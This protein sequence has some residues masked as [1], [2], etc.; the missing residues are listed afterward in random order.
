MQERKKIQILRPHIGAQ[1]GLHHFISVAACLRQHIAQRV[2]D[3]TA[4]VKGHRVLPAYAV[5]SGNEN[6][7]GDSVTAHH[8]TPGSGG[9]QIGR[10][11]LGTDRGRIVDEFRAFKRIDP[12]Q[13][14]KPLIV[15]RWALPD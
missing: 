7:I 14:G 5:A 2:A 1:H 6:A 11:R 3:E 9:I 12:R 10:R 13:L 8:C 15:S 4:A